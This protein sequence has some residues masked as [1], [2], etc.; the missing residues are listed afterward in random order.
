MKKIAKPSNGSV[1]CTFADCPDRDEHTKGIDGWGVRDNIDHLCPDGSHLSA[2]IMDYSICCSEEKPPKAF[3]ACQIG[4]GGAPV[5]IK[6]CEAALC[7]KKCPR[8]FVR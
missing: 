7:A 2:R 8:H 4:S 6:W 5:S 3:H 1:L